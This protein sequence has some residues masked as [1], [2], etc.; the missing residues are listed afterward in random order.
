MNEKPWR[1][2]KIIAVCSVGLGIGGL[3]YS[4]PVLGSELF[5]GDRELESDEQY[6]YVFLYLFSSLSIFLYIS[7]IICGIQLFRKRLNWVL[8]LVAIVAIE[9]AL[10]IGVG[11]SWLNPKYGMSI[12]GA[13]GLSFGGMSIQFIILFP[14]WGPMASLWAWNRIRKSG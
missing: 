11:G 8:A 4:L 10:V 13:T 6:F 7:L 9:I 14:L 1:V 5:Y 3:L 2:L 12:A